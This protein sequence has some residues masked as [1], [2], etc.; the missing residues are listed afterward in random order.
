[1]SDFTAGLSARQDP[2]ASALRIQVAA[3]AAG[4][5][6]AD[7]AANAGAPPADAPV[8]FSPR[9]PA[10]KHFSPADPEGESPTKGWDPLKPDVA[11]AEGAFVDV[12]AEAREQG[13]AEGVAAARLEMLRAAERDVALV[14]GIADALRAAN[15]IDRD[16]LAR[17]LREVVLA[18]ACRVVDEAGISA[19]RLAKR[20][21]AVVALIA[22][23]VDR[24]VLR[25]NPDDI[26]LLDGKLGA[27]IAV[28]ADPGI[29]RGGFAIEAPA[30]V[31]EDGPSLWAEQ[32]AHALDQ[33][34]VPDAG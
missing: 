5:V 20:I 34:A 3:A 23:Q 18:L 33:V 26:A 30:T 17:S 11:E 31:I 6:P 32:L 12:V 9:S 8:S 22:D 28:S 10:P 13:Y 15:H 7:L 25:L 4:F 29:E 2:A 27:A 14:T 21:D 1:M 19:D 24:A 16:G